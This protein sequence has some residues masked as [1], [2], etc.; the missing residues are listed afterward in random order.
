[1]ELMQQFLIVI[2]VEAGLWNRDHRQHHGSTSVHRAIAIQVLNHGLIVPAV[3]DF[4]ALPPG[5][6]DFFQSWAMRARSSAQRFCYD[7]N[8]TGAPVDA[9][10][11]GV[12][13]HALTHSNQKSAFPR[14]RSGIPIR[15][16]RDNAHNIILTC[17]SQLT[18]VPILEG[19]EDS[20]RDPPLPVA[21]SLI[22]FDLAPRLPLL[23]TSSTE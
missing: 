18:I 9:P 4:L 21:L 11:D 14:T 2:M 8:P 13:S 3:L 20:I 16:E 17:Q 5:I 1:M 6:S 15:G 12:A 10:I 7:R 19:L 23:L 22:S